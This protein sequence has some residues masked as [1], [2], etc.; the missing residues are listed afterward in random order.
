MSACPAFP[1]N[2]AAS[3]AHALRVADCL[4]DQATAAA[5]GR[6]FGAGGA[7]GIAL[8]SALTI[9][10]ALLAIDLLTGRSRLGLSMLTPRMMTLGL[11]LT[12]ATSWAA[13]QG[14][15]WNLL[16]GAPDQVAR[17]ITGT[18]GSAAAHF[19]Q[20]ID[21]IVDGLSTAAQAGAKEGIGGGGLS[22]TP[23][24]MLG[25]SAFILLL[26]TAGVLLTARIALAGLLAVGPVF[27]ILALF[28]GTRGLFDGWLRAAVLFAITPL[29]AVLIGSI[30]LTMVAPLI[31]GIGHGGEISLRMATVMLLVACIHMLL[32]VAAI[33]IAATITAGWKPA[34]VGKLDAER[35][36]D[37]APSGTTPIAAAT[38]LSGAASRISDER[39]GHM[40]SAFEA[41]RAADA[42]DLRTRTMVQ[43]DRPVPTTFSTP[44][45][46]S[47]DARVRQAAALLPSAPPI[48][49]D[50]VTQ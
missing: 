44:G 10:V 39:I 5:F 25:L 14:V 27:I 48:A 24:Q 42:M 50:A 22:P 6:L 13:Y 19:A 30:A 37:P 36:H 38:L 7:L 16:S 11:I 35:K 31:D 32:M 12:F 21:V 1:V 40:V 9:Y 43:G 8:T 20:R 2:G 23:A 34:S 18:Q 29:F 46:R 26:G 47:S 49:K 45:A 4:G 28:R 17:L 15:V 41:P 3:V 33:R